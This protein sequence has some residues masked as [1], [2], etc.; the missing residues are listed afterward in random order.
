VNMALTDLDPSLAIPKIR[1]GALA[2]LNGALGAGPCSLAEMKNTGVDLQ[3]PHGRK[4]SAALKN[5]GL[6]GPG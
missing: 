1:E 6:K 2:A 5:T 3:A 4:L